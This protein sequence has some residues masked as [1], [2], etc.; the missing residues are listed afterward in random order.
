MNPAI[1][2]IHLSL[3]LC[4]ICGCDKSNQPGENN[5]KPD[6]SD[7]YK[8]LIMAGYQG[9]FNAEGDGAGRGWNHY[10]KDGRFEPGYCKLIS[11]PKYQSTPLYIKPAFHLQTD[12]PPTSSAPM[13]RVRLILISGGCRSTELMEYLCN[14]LS[15]LLKVLW[16]TATH[17]KYWNQHLKQQKNITGSF[18]LCMICPE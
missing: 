12:L 15:Q 2:I 7:S 4:T 9:W 6:P 13:M 3:I 1:L 10:K 16:V 14:V 17:R 11:G 18:A 5:N 8:G